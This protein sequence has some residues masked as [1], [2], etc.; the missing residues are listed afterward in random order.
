[1]KKKKTTRRAGG[2]HRPLES[3]LLSNFDPSGIA[4]ASPGAVTAESANDLTPNNND[5]NTVTD[6]GGVLTLNKANAA[7]HMSFTTGSGINF[8][9]VEAMLV[10]DKGAGDG[11]DP[12]DDPPIYID[13]SA[14]STWVVMWARHRGEI[15]ARFVAAVLLVISLFVAV[16]IIVTQNASDGVSDVD[17]P[18]RQ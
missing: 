18:S 9:P 11:D 10:P 4:A 17:A 8:F 2:I 5:V 15:I 14:P 13:K 3:E 6:K 7:T 16:D 12:V 1:M